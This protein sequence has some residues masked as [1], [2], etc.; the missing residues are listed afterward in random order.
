MITGAKMSLFGTCTNV[1]LM[2]IKTDITATYGK[3]KKGVKT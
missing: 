3:H 2:K 1:Y